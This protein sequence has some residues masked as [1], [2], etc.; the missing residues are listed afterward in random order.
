MRPEPVCARCGG[1]LRPPGLWSSRW[2]C[3]RDGAVEP[4]VVW[5]RVGPDTLDYV[6]TKSTV[7]LWIPWPLPHGWVLSG[8]AYAGDEREGAHASVVA[9]T[10]PS[11]LGGAAELL[12][13][14]ED[15]G[16]GLGA[17]YAGMEGMD[18]GDGI[19]DGPPDAKISAAGHPTPLWLVPAAADAAVFV[20]EAKGRWL[21]L[22]LWPATAGVL[23]Y[24]EL[25]LLDAAASDSR[26]RALDLDYG[27]LSPRL[28]V[29]PAA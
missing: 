23:A 14:A 22:L 5:P 27:A 7:P 20:G 24:D 4:Y 19:G 18:P 9:C 16:V 12:L 21:W 29:P 15:P 28:A 13:I 6:R 17:R 26:D 11:P 1:P 10:G 25:T 2:Q 8:L 3:E